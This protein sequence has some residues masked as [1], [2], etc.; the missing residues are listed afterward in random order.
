M[1][2]RPSESPLPR[3][4]LG[5]CLLCALAL[6]APAWAQGGDI[7]LDAIDSAA[8]LQADAIAAAVEERWTEAKELAIRALEKEASVTT[9]QARLV[10]ARAYEAL[11]ELAAADRQI[12][13]YLALP[14]LDRDRERGVEVKNRLVA[15]LR[16]VEQP[17]A[18]RSAPPQQARVPRA[19]GA[20]SAATRQ[21]RAGGIGLLAG[22]AAPTIVGIW[23]VATDVHWAQNGVQSG[24]W[25]AIG[26]PV[27]ITGIV[28]EAVGAALLATAPNAG[29]TRVRV[30]AGIAP[31][32]DGLSLGV[33]GRF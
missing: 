21:Q 32:P 18:P 14:L 19:T 12:D 9:A 5:L 26:A 20:V 25:A 31:S 30:S 16:R 4:F 22:G 27:L 7:D 24:T 10:L 1:L 28:L 15:A 3:A 8:A 17:T 6:A 11:G 29:K 13:N 33:W 2:G 23:F